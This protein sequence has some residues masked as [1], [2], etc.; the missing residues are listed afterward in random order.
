V[1]RI[2]DVDQ[3]PPVVVAAPATAL[4]LCHADNANDNLKGFK[5][6]GFIQQNGFFGP[7]SGLLP[8]KMRYFSKTMR[9]FANLERDVNRMR[10][11]MGICD[12]I[13]S[14]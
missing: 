11:F 13:K 2:S 7:T 1:N 9:L 3:G 12:S 4:H 14:S 10:E 8:P 6:R 5:T